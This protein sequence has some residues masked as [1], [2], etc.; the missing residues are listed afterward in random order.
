M[1][2]KDVTTLTLDT[3]QSEARKMWDENYRL[4]TMTAVD[5][6]NESFD[7]LYHFDR[8]LELKHYRLTVPKETAI[9]SISPIYFAALLIE[10]EIK[11]HFGANFDGLILDFGGHLYLEDEV[12]SAPFCRFSISKKSK[13]EG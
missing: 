10:N 12:Q 5:L 13:E 11:D 6:K 9:P 4:V 8:D 1:S 7:I 3:V 2:V